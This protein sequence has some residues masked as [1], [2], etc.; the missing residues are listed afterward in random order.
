[1]K[2]FLSWSGDRS[3]A[4]GELLKSWIPD[5]IQAVDIWIATD[6]EKGLRWAQELDGALE[7]CDFGLSVVTPENMEAPWLLFEAGAISKSVTKSKVYT[8]LI[9]GLTF[10][11]LVGPLSQFQHT[12]PVEDDVLKLLHSIN[13]GLGAKALE[14]KRLER[15]FKK[16]W[17]DLDRQLGSTHELKAGIHPLNPAVKRISEEKLD[18]LLDRIR[19]V[20]RRLEKERS[21]GSTRLLKSG[22][23]ELSTS[24]TDPVSSWLDLPDRLRDAISIAE[25]LDDVDRDTAVI[26]ANMVKRMGRI[27]EDEELDALIRLVHESRTL[28]T[29]FREGR[30]QNLDLLLGS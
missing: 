7:T 11:D 5:V 9:G 14:E 12:V 10:S 4:V 21:R 3:R 30:L 13:R 8:F 23:Y 26:V 27:P 22:S 20:E 6:I 19:N 15:L 24:S 18:E 17:P 1:M 2:I 25:K 28:V 16:N 29:A